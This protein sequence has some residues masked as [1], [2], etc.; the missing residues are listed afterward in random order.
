MANFKNFDTNLPYQ[1]S[2]VSWS[3]EKISFYNLPM[4][5]KKWNLIPILYFLQSINYKNE[6]TQTVIKLPDSTLL[7]MLHSVAF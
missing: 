3:D 1:T 2:L 7:S 5:R 4:Q 6:F